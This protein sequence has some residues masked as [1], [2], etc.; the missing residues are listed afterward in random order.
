MVTAVAVVFPPLKVPLA[1]LPGAVKVTAAPLTGLLLASVT[2]ADMAIAK[3]ALTNALCVV[4]P[5]A[6]IVAGAGA[7]LVPPDDAA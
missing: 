4:P 6:V 2:I 7:P 3:A 1:P 5:V